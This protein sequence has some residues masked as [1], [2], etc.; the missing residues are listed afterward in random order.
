[1]KKSITYLLTLTLLA[2]PSMGW[3]LHDD[4]HITIVK[5]TR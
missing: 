5:V 4:T 1:M 2:L 3:A